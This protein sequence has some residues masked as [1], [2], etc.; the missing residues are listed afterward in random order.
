MSNLSHVGTIEL[1]LTKRGNYHYFSLRLEFNETVEHYYCESGYLTAE[2]AQ[3]EG[4]RLVHAVSMRM[5]SATIPFD[6]L[7]RFYSQDIPLDVLMN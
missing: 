1:I 3:K 5:H 4:Q 2:E 7:T 6:L